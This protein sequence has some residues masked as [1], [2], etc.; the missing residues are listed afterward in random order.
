M[1]TGLTIA[2]AGLPVLSPQ[3]KVRFQQSVIPGLLRPGLS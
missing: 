2:V 3:R 1:F